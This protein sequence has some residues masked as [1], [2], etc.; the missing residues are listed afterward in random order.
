MKCIDNGKL[1]HQ[2]L[3]ARAGAALIS[4]ERVIPKFP[5]KLDNL[6]VKT[7]KEELIILPGQNYKPTIL[8]KGDYSLKVVYD[9]GELRKYPG[10]KNLTLKKLESNELF[11]KIK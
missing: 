1:F 8:K 5:H 10:G 11:F 2:L 6:E 3:C 4:E 7:Y 9:T